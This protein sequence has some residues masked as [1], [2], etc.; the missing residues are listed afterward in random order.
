MDKIELLEKRIKSLEDTREISNLMGRYVYLHT[1]CLH[2]ETADMFAKHTPGVKAEI[3]PWGVYEG[4]EGIQKLYVGVHSHGDGDRTG[5]MY[6]H[7]LTTPV[8]EVA[9]D[10]K[11]A[12]GLWISPGLE[13]GKTNNKLQAYWVWV[14]YAV[15]FVKEDGRWKFW[16][17]HI[18]GI[19]YTSYEKSWVDYEN[20][21]AKS[22]PVLPDKLKAN[23]PTTYFWEYTPNKKTENVPVPPEPYEA[24]D[25]SLSCIQ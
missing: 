15:D 2:Q 10:G 7:T 23:R 5:L 11:T 3:G 25:E 20:P 12:K 21:R 14:K 1:A 17:T 24:W 4:N 13:T 8:I 22:P 19:L 6:M 16:H 18:H 9:G